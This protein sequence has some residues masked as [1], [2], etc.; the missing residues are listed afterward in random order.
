MLHEHLAGVLAEHVDQVVFHQV[1]APHL[2]RQRQGGAEKTG[3]LVNALDG[4]RPGGVVPMA[5][6]FH[7]AWIQPVLVGGLT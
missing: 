6:I 4:H 1:P 2:G 7:R 5:A 3:E